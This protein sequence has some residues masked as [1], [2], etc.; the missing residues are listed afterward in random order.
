VKSRVSRARRALQASLQA[1]A[2][3]KDGR[4]AGDAMGSILG[5]ADRLSGAR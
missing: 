2:Y 1:G 3:E 4:P 5:E